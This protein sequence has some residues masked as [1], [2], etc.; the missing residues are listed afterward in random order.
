MMCKLTHSYGIYC[1]YEGVIAMESLYFPR[2]APIVLN[3]NLS[4]LYHACFELM[5]ITLLVPDFYRTNL[6]RDIS[7]F[8]HATR[9][10]FK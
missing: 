6:E 2:N 8:M 4:N 3:E 5:E 7:L 1:I 10:A 9:P